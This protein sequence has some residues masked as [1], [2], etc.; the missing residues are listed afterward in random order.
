MDLSYNRIVNIP[1][2][3]F[4]RVAKS[5]K[6]LNLE[7]NELHAVPMALKYLVSLEI[8]NMN[9]NKLAR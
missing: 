7:E 9:G 5:L 8:L 1:K 4:S 2:N 6:K 3:T